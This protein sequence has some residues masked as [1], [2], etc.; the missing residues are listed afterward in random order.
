M[1]SGPDVLDFQESF[2][3]VLVPGWGQRRDGAVGKGNVFF[4]IMLA[5]GISLAA[6][7]LLY[8]ATLDDY[9]QNFDAYVVEQIEGRRPG[10]VG[11]YRR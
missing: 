10:P 1:N 3:S 7:N 8:E 11:R 9:Q 4:G 6:S 5:G 2:R